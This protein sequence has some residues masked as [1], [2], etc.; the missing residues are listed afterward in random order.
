MVGG[1][2]ITVCWHVDDLKVSHVMSKDR[3]IKRSRQE[4]E[5]MFKDG[6]GA[7]E[8]SGGETHKHCV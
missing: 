8:V 6:S 2:Q 4:H 3:S 1:K 5:S 7:M